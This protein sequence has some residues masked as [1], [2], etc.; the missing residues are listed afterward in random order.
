MII[1]FVGRN[2]KELFFCRQKKESRSTA[3]LILHFARRARSADMSGSFGKGFLFP[4]LFCFEWYYI[5]LSCERIFDL[6][7][8]LRPLKGK[9][10][11]KKRYMFP[12]EKVVYKREQ[13]QFINERCEFELCS[14]H[15]P[16]PQNSTHRC[17]NPVYECLIICPQSP[18]H[19]LS[20]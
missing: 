4:R 8:S 1:V 3:T 14:K 5:L 17:R 20:S 6:M 18:H 19:N 12:A 11:E 7:V 16:R 15:S 10:L 9:K 13:E 2:S